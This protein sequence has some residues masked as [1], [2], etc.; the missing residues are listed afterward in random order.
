MSTDYR[1]KLGVDENRGPSKEEESGEVGGI[2]SVWI[3]GS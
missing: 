2:R 1:E 3:D